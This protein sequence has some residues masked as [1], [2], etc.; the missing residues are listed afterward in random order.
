MRGGME[1]A[2]HRTA[3]DRLTE[4]EVRVAFYGDL[5]RPAGTKAGGG[6]P[7]TSAHLT[8]FEREL[9]QVWY[10]RAVAQET[11]SSLGENTKGP[12]S[13]AVQFM[14]RRLLQSQAFVGV[15]ERAFVGNLKQTV[16]FLTNLEVKKRVLQRIADEVTAETTVI[17]GHSLGS[18]VAYEY[19]VQ[20]RPPQVQLL[21]TAGSPLGIPKVVFDRLTPAPVEG[22]GAWP[23]GVA[24][25]V[26]IADRND[27]VALC[28]ELAPLFLSLNGGPRVKDLLVD[29]G[30]AS[31]GIEPYLSSWQAGQALGDIL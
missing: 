15:A 28:K 19:L 3:A 22:T 26:N 18:V 24:N 13:I 12:P 25:W 2:R 8:S 21:I 11:A 30:K 29:N 14:L 31:H 17:I 27:V 5:F 9:L 1:S 10:E 16:D 6:A 23:G 20:Y 7:Y 4:D